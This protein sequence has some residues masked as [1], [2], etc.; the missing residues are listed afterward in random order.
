MKGLL[1]DHE[2]HVNYAKD[3]SPKEVAAAAPDALLFGGP[4][5]IGNISYTLRKWIEK[6]A[7]I[8]EKNKLSL[9]KVAAWETKGE[10]KE[11]EL[12]KADGMERKV[13]EKNLKTPE[14]WHQLIQKIPADK[15]PVELLGLVVE[16][17][18][19]DDLSGA[20]LIRGYEEKIADFIQKFEQ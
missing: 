18:N 19:N 17:P 10:I 9:K 6:F 20:V 2:V 11:E 15:N 16:S 14:L 7:K 4:R 12:T 1:K 13:Y 3:I 5:R 8:L